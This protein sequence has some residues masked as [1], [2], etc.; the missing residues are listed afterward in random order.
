M[1]DQ[2]GEVKLE[3]RILQIKESPKRRREETMLPSQ[4]LLQWEMDTET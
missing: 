1:N 2:N 3:E 4:R